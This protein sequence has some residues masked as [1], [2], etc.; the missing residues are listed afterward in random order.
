[1]SLTD[2]F[3]KHINAH[4]IPRSGNEGLYAAIDE[5][6]ALL[7]IK[8]PEIHCAPSIKVPT[9]P[10][11]EGI[12]NHP[13]A[14]SLSKDKIFISQPMLDL[15]E[16]QDLSKPISEELKAILGHEMHHCANRG[17]LMAMRS[18]PVFA[19]PAI[20][21]AATYLYDHAKNKA[22]HEKD[23]SAGNLVKHIDATAKDAD[24]QLREQQENK[25]QRHEEAGLK[26]NILHY[27][28]YFAIG[29]AGLGAGLLTS[30]YGSRFHE[31]AAD[32]F[33]ASVTNKEAAISALRKIHEAMGAS[34]SEHP[35]KE[36]FKGLINETMQAHP[37]FAERAAHIRS[38]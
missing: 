38:L 7:R 32:R 15:F 35:E 30:R 21:V 17:S 3:L 22:E 34:I 13:N 5:I 26:R 12:V 18:L 29:V 14:A 11:I 36:A 6:A 37:S 10:L 16:A 31:F 9:H 1:M 19:L 20:A 4:P 24:R 25:P 2:S 23:V 33:G 27:G 8:A 28:K